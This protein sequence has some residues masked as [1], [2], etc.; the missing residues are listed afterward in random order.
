HPSGAEQVFVTSPP[1]TLPT[2]LTI[3][4][5]GGTVNLLGLDF[6][7]VDILFGEN[8]PIV[9][10]VNSNAHMKNIRDVTGIDVAEHIAAH[11]ANEMNKRG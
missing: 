6:G 8:G 5:F 10:E 2:A 4:R 1:K 11:I 9:C 3:T 7:G